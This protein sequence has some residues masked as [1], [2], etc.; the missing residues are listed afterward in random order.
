MAS[1]ATPEPD[2]ETSSSNT[3]PNSATR[4]FKDLESGPAEYEHVVLIVRSMTCSGCEQKLKAAIDTIPSVANVRTNLIRS[5]AEFD[6]DLKHGSVEEALA[7]LRRMTPYGFRAI[8]PEHRGFL[9]VVTG[10][11][12]AVANKPPPEGVKYM[13]RLDDKTVRIYFRPG[14]K[15]RDALEEILPADLELTP[16]EPDYSIEDGREQVRME[17]IVFAITLVLT[18]PVL[19]FAWTPVKGPKLAYQATSLVLAT[20]VQAI[21]AY[22]FYPDTF[23][24]LF[25]TRV[26]EMELLIALSTTAA[27]AFSVVAFAYLAKGQ[28]LS[29]GSFFETSTLL[30]TLIMF[31]RY[32]QQ[33]ARQRAT[34]AISIRSLQPEKALLVDGQNRE[35]TR[36]TDA[37]LLQEG[38]VFRMPPHA[39]IVTDGKVVYGG[40]VVDESMV[41][42]E[43]NPVA[44]GIHSSVVAGSVN[45]DGSLDIA[46]TRPPWD[47][48]VSAIAQM[49]DEADMAKS[50]AQKLA[51]NVATYFVP[52]ILS[53]TVIVFVTWMLVGTE[54]QDKSNAGAAVQAATYA[55]ATLIVSCPCAISLAVPMV[56]AI[57]S[58][59]AA[60]YGVIFRSSV[61]IE[62][63][64]KVTHVVFDKTGTLTEGRMKVVAHLSHATRPDL[65]VRHAGYHVQY[66]TSQKA[67]PTQRS[68]QAKA[69][70][71]FAKIEE[72]DDGGCMTVTYKI[73]SP[74]ISS[75][76]PPFNPADENK[77]LLELC[78][79]V[80][81]PVAA[82]VHKYLAQAP[83][84]SQSNV[85][86]SS[87]KEHLGQ[88]IEGVSADGLLTIR[89]GDPRWLGID[90]LPT[91]LELSQH[92]YSLFGY[93]FN[94][95]LHGLIGLEDDFRTEAHD[96]V[97]RLSKSGIRV[98]IISG[99]HEAAVQQVARQLPIPAENVH[100]RLTPED[101]LEFIRKLQ[102]EDK[103]FILFC[104]DGT[105]DAAALATADIGVHM[106]GGTDVAR[107]AAHVVLMRP[108]LRGVLTVLQLSKS[109]YIKMIVNFIWSFVYNV[110]AV[111][112]AAGAFSA[113]RG[114][115]IPPA[116]A[117]L[118]E[119]VSVL[120]V[121][122]I[123]FL[124]KLERFGRV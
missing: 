60:K 3:S 66:Q 40:S 90:S 32:I 13:E 78:A 101:K 24:S 75:Q 100:A 114:V 61:T 12:A 22:H 46:V 52:L 6:I 59:V 117:G 84:T 86:L 64:R 45:L 124:L 54:F 35:H 47:N 20:L 83:A 72:K 11:A 7:H 81:H 68:Q 71:P 67:C 121:V 14:A 48:T 92:G 95:E 69:F 26:V 19:V 5:R 51:D 18:I 85:A 97:K 57:A 110:F 23:K 88:G 38:D 122:G 8:N 115:R 37:R 62:Q 111:A 74:L 99:D 9:D 91:T 103:E 112:L 65:L 29:I 21:A 123:A 89:A 17:G 102:T 79:N 33:L 53:I 4:L 36:E 41:T 118:G 55:I 105:N 50:P 43:T 113:L 76:L 106:Q 27:Y 104:G 107:S 87:K 82:A 98:S 49:I 15:V 96:V 16:P 80:S 73:F 44:K 10:D 116:Y 28:P 42:G 109:A 56:V 34:E 93:T 94:G 58:G 120:P 39:T 30:T 1:N 119:L 108:D 25:R 2:S 63:A 77:F 31:G 70:H